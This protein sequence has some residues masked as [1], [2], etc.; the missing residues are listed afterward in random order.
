MISNR[1]SLPGTIMILASI[2][3]LLTT[4]CGEKKQIKGKEFVPRD[5][6]VDMMVDIHLLDG[7][8]NDVI[9]YRM[10]N[11]NDSIDLYGNVFMEFGYDRATFDSTLQEY[12]RYPYILDALYDDV[13][14]KLNLMLDQ[15]N[16]EEQKIS[17]AKKKNLNLA[18][19]PH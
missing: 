19:K 14:M 5:E 8:T 15:M 9:Y 16:Q 2:I 3:V 13:M 12:A 1:S 6:M 7:I 18:P 10:Y 11:P 17:D 4:G